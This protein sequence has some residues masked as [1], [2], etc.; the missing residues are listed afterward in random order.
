MGSDILLHGGHRKMDSLLRK[1]E[2][3]EACLKMGKSKYIQLNSYIG[4]REKR[5]KS[6]KERSTD[7]SLK[8]YSDTGLF[9]TAFKYLFIDIF[10]HHGFTRKIVEYR[11][12]IVSNSFLEVLKSI[13]WHSPKWKSTI[14]KAYIYLLILLECTHISRDTLLHSNC[15]HRYFQYEASTRHSIVTVFHMHCFHKTLPPII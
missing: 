4:S 3:Q 12:C 13:L 8:C 2:K 14:E 1:I 7:S 5:K 11:L 10:Y 15:K 6:W 9:Q